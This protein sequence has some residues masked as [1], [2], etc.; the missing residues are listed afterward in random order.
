MYNNE[1]WSTRIPIFKLCYIPACHVVFSNKCINVT[2]HTCISNLISDKKKTH[3][4]FTDSV[5]TPQMYFKSICFINMQDIG[6][7]AVKHHY[8]G[9]IITIILL[10]VIG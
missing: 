2:K 5:S 4:K 10:D 9:D 8:K 7:T 6:K 1:S 3:I